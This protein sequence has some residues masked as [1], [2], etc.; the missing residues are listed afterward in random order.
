LL[1]DA[2]SDRSR[3]RTFEIANCDLKGRKQ[4]SVVCALA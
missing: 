1:C 2:D 4:L 3:D